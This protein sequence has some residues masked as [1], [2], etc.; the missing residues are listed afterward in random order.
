[1]TG[2][3][4]AALALF[5]V[6]TLAAGAARGWT[7]EELEATIAEDRA[8]VERGREEVKALK[9]QI[10]RDN[11]T[12]HRT[13]LAQDR[14]RLDDAE[15]RLARDKVQ[16]RDRKKALKRLRKSLKTAQ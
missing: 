11:N 13:G 6:L 8:R 9:A 2:L 5:V 10:F 12:L 1:M 15:N 14:A 16:L 4:S 3:R 7:V